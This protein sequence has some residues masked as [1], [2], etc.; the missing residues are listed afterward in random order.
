MLDIKWWNIGV[1]MW[2]G[3]GSETAMMLASPHTNI[4]QN[5]K[6]ILV[7]GS[8]KNMNV[9]IEFDLIGL[10]TNTIPCRYW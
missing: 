8:H 7:L 1:V 4:L 9:I 6:L 5:L 10:I 3:H 2:F